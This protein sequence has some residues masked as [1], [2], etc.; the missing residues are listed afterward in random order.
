MPDIISPLYCAIPWDWNV[1]WGVVQVVAQVTAAPLRFMP[2]TLQE[3]R[4]STGTVR[5]GSMQLVKL[6]LISVCEPEDG[7]GMS[8]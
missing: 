8:P 3:K 2:F 7:A 5:A 1:P 6:P 4:G